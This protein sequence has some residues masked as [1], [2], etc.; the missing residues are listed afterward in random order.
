MEKLNELQITICPL[1]VATGIQSCHLIT[2]SRAPLFSV[3]TKPNVTLFAREIVDTCHAVE[4]IGW[5]L[6]VQW[7]PAHVGVFG[8]EAA[9]HLSDVAYQD[10]PGTPPIPVPHQ[11]MCRADAS[12]LHRLR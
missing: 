11:D 1:R 4:G 9:D 7:A 12:L 5:T 8:N 3:T 10:H 6:H 2:H